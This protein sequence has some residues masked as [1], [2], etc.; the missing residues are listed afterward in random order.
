MSDEKK[1]ITV[2]LLKTFRLLILIAC[3]VGAYFCFKFGIF[4]FI[5]EKKMPPKLETGIKTETEVKINVENKIK[6]SDWQVTVGDVKE[7][8]QPSA[9]VKFGSKKGENK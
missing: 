5:L 8:E 4:D 9:E 7:G 2:E 6:G 3:L 1:N